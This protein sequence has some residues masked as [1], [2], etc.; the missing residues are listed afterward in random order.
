VRT[1]IIRLQEDAGGSGRTGTA[2]PRLR[3]FVDEVAS[4]LRAKFRSERELLT[5]L[6]AALTL[7][8]PGPPWRGEDG[9]AGEP[10]SDRP[11]PALEED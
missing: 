4:G 10:S 2:T 8:P 9:A 1:F 7:D 11:D 5:A 3:G 6:T